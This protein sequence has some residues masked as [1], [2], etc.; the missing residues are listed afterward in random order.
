MM[1]VIALINLSLTVLVFFLKVICYVPCPSDNQNW[2]P[3]IRV[4]YNIKV[5]KLFL[6]QTAP[7]MAPIALR[8]IPEKN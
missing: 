6:K 2:H 8:L 7:Q 5:L 1:Q 4:R 3:C